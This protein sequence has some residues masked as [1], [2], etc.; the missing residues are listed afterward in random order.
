M[1]FSA[2]DGGQAVALL[3]R[4]DSGADSYLL[5]PRGLEPEALYTVESI[6]SG[7]D[8]SESGR[9]LMQSGT[10]VS[11]EMKEASAIVLI[12]KK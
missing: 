6:D 3:F 1:E 5:R 10:L 9:I 7:L 4:G 8:T 12:T 2:W 11:L